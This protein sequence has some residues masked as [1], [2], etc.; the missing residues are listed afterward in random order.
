MLIEF[1][2]KIISVIIYIFQMYIYN[3]IFS[4]SKYVIIKTLRVL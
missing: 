1:N 3:Y 4:K 2:S